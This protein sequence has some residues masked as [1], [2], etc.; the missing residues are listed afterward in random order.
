MSM[1]VS[2][3]NIVD[4]VYNIFIKLQGTLHLVVF[5]VIFCLLLNRIFSVTEIAAGWVVGLEASI[6]V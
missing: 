4:D 3:D 2:K 6:A 1:I 5:I